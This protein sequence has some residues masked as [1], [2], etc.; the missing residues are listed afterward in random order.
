VPRRSHRSSRRAPARMLSV[1]LAGGGVK[2]ASCRC[3]CTPLANLRTRT[4]R[5]LACC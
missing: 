2:P 4:G 5:P 1:P 3:R